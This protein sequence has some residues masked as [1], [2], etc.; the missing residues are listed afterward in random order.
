MQLTK[1]LE[2]VATLSKGQLAVFEVLNVTRD[3]FTGRKVVPK[4]V[5]VP[6]SDRI[7]ASDGTPFDLNYIIKETPAGP[8]SHA[9]TI[10]HLG[11]M[12]FTSIGRGQIILSGDNPKDVAMF[13][14][15]K[16]TNFNKS[17][18]GTFFHVKPTAYIFKEIDKVA[19]AADERKQRRDIREA[20]DKIDLMNLD[21]L[22]HACRAMSL[23]SSASKDEMI[24]VLQNESKKDPAAFLKSLDGKEIEY[25]GNIEKAF[26]Y[27][28]IE[29][30]TGSVKW[31]QGGVFI[32]VAKGT[33]VNQAIYEFFLTEKGRTSYNRMLKLIELWEIDLTAE[34]E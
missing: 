15:L 32:E 6:P 5:N 30:K 12:K 10:K 18:K 33:V 7:M 26:E 25:L 20:E 34:A 8:N 17:N 22:R 19:S 14:Y 21:V 2:K 24:V 1:E 3:K 27:G 13:K 31:K 11:L 4:S 29:K 9:T 28:V 23:N 16:L